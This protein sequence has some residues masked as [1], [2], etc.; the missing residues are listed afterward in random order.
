MT[1]LELQEHITNLIEEGYGDHT[2]CVFDPA[3]NSMQSL[4]GVIINNDGNTELLM[5]EDN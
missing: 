2:P 5:F 3:T 1:L 4:K